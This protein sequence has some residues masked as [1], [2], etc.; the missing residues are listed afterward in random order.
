MNRWPE[1]L[2]RTSPSGRRHVGGVEHM[3]QH[4]PG[5]ADPARAFGC[6]VRVRLGRRPRDSKSPIRARTVLSGSLSLSPFIIS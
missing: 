2:S 3:R 6:S 1:L 4:S 5:A